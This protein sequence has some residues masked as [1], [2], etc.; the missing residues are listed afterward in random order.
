MPSMLALARDLGGKYPNRFKMVAVS[1]DDGWDEILKFFDGKLPPEA[2][3]ALDQDMVATRAYYC[4][5]RGACPESFKFPETYIVDAEGRV[6]AYM[7]G[8][9]DWSDPAAR[10]V[11]E[12]IIEG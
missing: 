8:P 12:R 10:R 7:V 9:R 5:A 11:L 2:L 6:V 3:I 4:T 1:V